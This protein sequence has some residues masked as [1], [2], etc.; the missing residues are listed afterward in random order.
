M[1]GLWIFAYGSLIW[2]PG[3]PVQRRILAKVDGYRRGFYMLSV[4]HRGTPDLPGL[5]LALDKA[6]GASCKGSLLQVPR[7]SEDATLSYLRRRELISSAYLETTVT[8]EADGQHYKATTFIVDQKHNQYV[9]DLT[10]AE[11]VELIMQ[12]RGGRGTNLDYL[13]QTYVSLQEAGIPDPQ[14]DELISI[15][16]EI[17]RS[18]KNQELA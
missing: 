1:D 7:G 14:I 5:V 9:P 2:D 11:Q 16:S 10:P 17:T 3:F 4:H 8:A 6:E 12:A 13:W 18:S 15:V